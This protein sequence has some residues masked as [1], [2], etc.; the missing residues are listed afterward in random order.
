MGSRSKPFSDAEKEILMTLV[1]KYIKRIESKCTD[2]SS[3]T[4][5]RKAWDSLALEY[6]S[7]AEVTNRTS[8]QLKKGWENMKSKAKTKV[9]KEKQ[10][11]RLTGGGP[12]AATNIA[13]PIS[14]QIAA[15]IPEQ[16]EPIWNPLD[17]DAEYHLGE[18]RAFHWNL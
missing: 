10:E 4:S 17:E 11:R 16:I 5:K 18:Y 8:S 14:S 1:Q 6:N 7:R 2:F 15:I 13:D 12:I 3:V 9:G